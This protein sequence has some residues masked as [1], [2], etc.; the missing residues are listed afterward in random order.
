[1]RILGFCKSLAALAVLLLV[2]TVPAAAIIAIGPEF[3]VTINSDS[4]TLSNNSG[5]INYPTQLWIWGFAIGNP[6]ASNANIQGGL[7]TWNANTFNSGLSNAE[8][9]YINS[10][11]SY[12]DLTTD[13]GPNSSSSVFYFTAGSQQDPPYTLSLFDINHNEFSFT[14][15]TDGTGGVLTA[16]PESSTWAM[17]LLGFA[18]IGFTAYRR[19]SKPALMV[20]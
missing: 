20:A 13:I 5:T 6:G 9:E 16:V 17:L 14:A 15:N 2:T 19:K 1:M 8:L 18:G 7:P 10:P 11:S 4:Y 3:S 12:L